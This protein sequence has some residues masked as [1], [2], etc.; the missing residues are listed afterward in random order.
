MSNFQARTSASA[1]LPDDPHVDEDLSKPS[2]G[3]PLTGQ[4]LVD[5]RLV[6]EPTLQEE[7]ADADR[8]LFDRFVQCQG[9][10]SRPQTQL[11]RRRSSLGPESPSVP[12]AVATAP[13]LSLGRFWSCS[14]ASCTTCLARRSFMAILSSDKRPRRTTAL[15]CAGKA[16]ALSLFCN[17]THSWD[18]F[19]LFSA[20]IGVFGLWVIEPVPP[21]LAYRAVCARSRSQARTT[22]VEQHVLLRPRSMRQPDMGSARRQPGPAM[23]DQVTASRSGGDHRAP[24]RSSDVRGKQLART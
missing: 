22:P 17:T 13:G 24:S 7:L 21:K 8:R 3:L 6:R 4:G 19:S 9:R 15:P 10:G 16:I 14:F 2:A 11:W 23:S 1:A 5:L 12:S 18:R 20:R